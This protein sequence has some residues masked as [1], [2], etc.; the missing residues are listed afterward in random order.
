MEDFIDK[1]LSLAN[2]NKNVIFVFGCR[3]G[4]NIFKHKIFTPEDIENVLD[5]IKSSYR[6]KKSYQRENIFIKG[7]EEIKLVNNEK[8]YTIKTIENTL[9]TDKC[10]I[11]IESYK[12]DQYIIPSYHYYDEEYEQEII[13]YTIENAFRI[14]IIIRDN[15]HYLQL[16]AYKPCDKKLITKFIDMFS[17]I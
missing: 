7:N 11:F 17:N 15:K 6:N 8:H 13:E 1:H 16:I 9:F 5:Y 2:K 14:K 12:T 10:L 3:Q 4:E